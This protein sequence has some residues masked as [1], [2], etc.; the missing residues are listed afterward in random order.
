MGSF[1]NVCAKQ[2][3]LYIVLVCFLGA[4]A[5]KEQA[6]LLNARVH[7]LRHCLNR[8]GRECT[9]IMG[10]SWVYPCAWFCV[11]V[12]SLLHAHSRILRSLLLLG[13]HTPH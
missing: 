10:T 8:E 12:G 5:S 11:P 13:E 1:I 7:R 4:V 6:A 9:H 3:L 2:L